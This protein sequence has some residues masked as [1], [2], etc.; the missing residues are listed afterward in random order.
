MPH[1]YKEKAGKCKECGNSPVNH[2]MQYFVS[3]V[4]VWLG[5]V[6]FRLLG[7]R[8]F[9]PAIQRWRGR[10]ECA[11]Q[12]N[13][14]K[15]FHRLGMIRFGTE[16]EKAASY[17]SQVVWEEATRRGIEM[18]QAIFLGKYTDAYR[19]RV[20]GEWIY[21]ESLPIPPHFP[22]D[23][24]FWIDDKFLLKRVL[25]KEGIAVPQAASVSSLRG[26]LAA[27]RRIGSP[28]VVK[29]RSGSR[30]RH[31]TTN[32]RAEK[33]LARAFKSAQKLGRYVSIERNLSG[34]VCR[35]TVIGNKLAGFFKAEA[36][37]VVGDGSS[38]VR[39]LIA[40]RNAARHE[41]V[42]DIVLSQEHEDFLVRQGLALTA[43]PAKGRVVELTH[44]TGRLFGGETR[45]LLDTVHP[46]LK[47]TVER[48][49]R[50][51]NVPV[52]GFDLII[53][54]PEQDPDS[55][56]WGII[57]ANS[58]PFIDLHYLPLY[59][60]PSNPAAAVWDLWRSEKLV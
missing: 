12:A 55:Q 57:E 44:R 47:T 11:M 30:G 56:E 4:Q 31:T 9:P 15:S 14:F 49:A 45:E 18:Q 10:A 39:E 41:R 37:Q 59:G 52:V 6:W 7:T 29:P 21:F 19:A 23:S 26:A 24:Y 27:F 58:L 48:A 16:V 28:V 5:S 25:G 32:V 60:K 51:L 2:A 38:T 43:V 20:N 13:N 1:E 22:Q 54:E 8:G 50:V 36:P 34:S 53:A 42:Q 35:A 17:R 33:E 3:T 46:K 40:V